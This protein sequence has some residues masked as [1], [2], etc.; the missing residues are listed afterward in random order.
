MS[1]LKRILSKETSNEVFAPEIM[2]LRLG[3]SFEVDGLFLRFISERLMTENINPTQIIESVGVV[4]MGDSTLMRF[5]TDDEGFLQV[6]ISGALKEENITDV[7]LFH[8]YNTI[9][10]SSDGDW[11]KLLDAEIGPKSYCLDDKVYKRVW[12]SL[13]DYHPPVAMTEVTYS[14][15]GSTLSTDQFTM[16]FERD[17]D[18]ESTESLFLSAEESVDSF[19]NVSRCL[20]ISTGITLGCSQITIHG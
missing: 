6:V 1:W 3:C 8:F 7:K 13:S 11:N 4:D 17:I 2:G 18:A 9:D 20:V 12:E 19:S 5:Y 10:I 15:D 16:L 14:A